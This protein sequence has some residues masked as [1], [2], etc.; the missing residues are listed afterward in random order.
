MLDF[1]PDLS[2]RDVTWERME[3][4]AFTPMDA[5]ARNQL[6][7]VAYGDIA[8][9]M[10]T[11]LGSEDASFCAIGQWASAAIAGYL[12]VPVPFIRRM[13]SR[14]FAFGNRHIFSEVARAQV[15]FL[16]EW[17]GHAEV[18]NSAE[19]VRQWVAEVKGRRG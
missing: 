16:E 12:S 18:L 3:A 11:V 7:T 8:D 15:A 6:I 19:A 17:R 5:R 13:V 2:S 1:R 9:A 10:A 4:V 14:P